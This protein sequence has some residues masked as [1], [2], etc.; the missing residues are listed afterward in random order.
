MNG[1]LAG[2]LFIIGL[3]TAQPIDNRNKGEHNANPIECWSDGINNVLESP[4]KK[5]GYRCQNTLQIHG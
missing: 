1:S 5:I 4:L 2:G 3:L